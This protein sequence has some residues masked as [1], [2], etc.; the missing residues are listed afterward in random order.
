MKSTTHRLFFALWPD[1][2]LRAGVKKNIQPYIQN[3]PA[4]I[5]P[6]NNWHVT[7]AFLGNVSSET[8]ACL[9]QQAGLLEGKRFTLQLDQFGYFERARVAWLGCND[10]PHEMAALFDKLNVA[11]APCGYQP[12]FKKFVPHMTLL[13][14]ASKGLAAQD[15]KPITWPVNEFVLVE[16][17]PTEPIEKGVIYNVINRW[18]LF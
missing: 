6:V 10:V 13:R 5:V 9:Q 18:Q 4:K 8:K 17:V 3:H 2:D 15:V 14:K 7:L 12:D 11:L 16:S 1:E